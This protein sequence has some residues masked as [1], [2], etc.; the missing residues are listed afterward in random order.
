MNSTRMHRI[1]LFLILLPFSQYATNAEILDE[2][3]FECQ[4][5]C[6]SPYGVTLGATKRDVEAY[7][8]CNTNCIVHDPNH[9]NGEYTGIKW[10]C[11]EYA[12]RWLLANK[13]V[14]FS[15]VNIAA[16][17]WHQ[18]DYVTDVDTNKTHSLV[19]KLNG[20]ELP[21]VMGDLLVY[22]ESF[23]DTG[24]VAI[25]VEVNHEDGFIKVGEQNYH[26]E[27]W[28][29][30]F[31]RTIELTKKGQNYWLLDEYLIGWKRIN[32]R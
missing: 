30:D 22:G 5:D 4:I 31:S 2:I 12:R 27:P 9:W 20:S 32:Q 3:P 10:Q 28:P 29:G 15:E 25:V 16:D 23:N 8:N 7:S 1:F 24:H 18:L 17:I 14:T 11:V 13:G 19:A 26:N 21:P 6:K